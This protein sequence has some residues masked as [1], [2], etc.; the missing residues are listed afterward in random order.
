VLSNTGYH[1]ADYMAS[2]SGKQAPEAL[3]ESLFIFSKSLLDFS[4]GIRAILVI[5]T[6]HLVDHLINIT[7]VF[8]RDFYAYFLKDTT[9]VSKVACHLDY[10]VQDRQE[11]A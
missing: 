1:Y 11:G 10:L 9:D 5:H 2:Y 3:D 8:F 6:Y 4:P 7:L